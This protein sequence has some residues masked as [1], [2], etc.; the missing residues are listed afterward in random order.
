MGYK[1]AITGLIMAIFFLFLGSIT[2]RPPRQ[3]NLMAV[4]G[5]LML[6]G[7]LMMPIG[8]IVQVWS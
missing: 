7:M 3:Q 1:I 6:I 5:S 4:R 8:L 2:R